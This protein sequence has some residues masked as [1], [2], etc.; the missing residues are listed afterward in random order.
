MTASVQEHYG[1]SEIVTRILAAVP[2]SSD[3]GSTLKVE[4]LYPFDQLHG[5]ELLATQDHATRLNPARGAHLLDIGSGVGGPARYFARTFGC[6]VT[7]IDLTPEFVAASRELGDLC[8]LRDLLTFIEAD[9]AKLPFDDDTFD[10]AC[11]FYV[12]MNL[13]DKAAVLKECIRVL[14]PGGKLIWTEVTAAAGTPHYPL[15]WSRTLDGSHIQTSADLVDTFRS[16]GFEVLSFEDETGAHLELARQIKMS[17]RVPLPGQ[18]Q[19]NEVVLGADFAPRR[20]NYI[21]SLGEGL[22][23]STLIEARKPA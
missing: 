22:I 8:G 21:R 2:W 17:G 14:R 6:R 15:P 18:I 7:G 1:T 10:H 19:A 16:A 9:A 23:A 20:A 11:S 5:R 12:G 4:Q 13:P 3:M